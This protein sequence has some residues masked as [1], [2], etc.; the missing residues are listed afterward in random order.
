MSAWRSLLFF[1]FSSRRRHTR[2]LCDWSSDVCSSDLPG[3]ALPPAG[4]VAWWRAENNALDALGANPGFL[5]NGV[6]F[7]AGQIGQAFQFSGANQEVKV[8]A[9]PSLNVGAGSGLTI[10]EWIKPADLLTQRPLAEWNDGSTWGSHFWINVAFSGLGGPG[11]IYANL[12]DINSVDH[13][14][15]SPPGLLSTNAWQHVAV[16][17]DL[18]SGM[19]QLFVNGA[20][21]A[22]VNL[23]FFLP[24]P[25]TDFYLGYRPGGASYLGRLHE[26]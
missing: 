2:S 3:F 4:M 18:T 1:F 23:C 6:A 26:H 13:Y 8:F 21:V 12:R 15:F 19:G 25:T 10:E 16:T 24:R 11:C 22:S 14:Y 17:Y 9:S 7:A 5:S 20:V